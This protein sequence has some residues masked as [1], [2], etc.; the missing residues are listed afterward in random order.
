VEERCRSGARGRLRRRLAATVVAGLAGAMAVA[1]CADDPA[2]PGPP[3]ATGAPDP[4]AGPDL[5]DADLWLTFDDDTPGYDASREFPDALGGPFAG[6]IVAAND[7]R[8]EM[9]AGAGGSGGAVAFPELCKASAGCPR[10]MV[11]V[12]ADPR[13]NPGEADF[14]YGASVWLA[15]DQ[16]TTGSNIVQKGRFGTSGG[17]WKLQ[18]DSADGEPSCVVRSGGEPV[19]VRSSVTI[20]DEAWHRVVCRRA[21]GAV[22]I[23]V[24]GTVDRGAASPGSV[25]NEWPVRI[26]SPG[27]DDGDDQFHG[28]VDDVFLKIEG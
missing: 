18:V 4:G 25:S 13:L 22:S 14:S 1:G 21:E 20:A 27:V 12:M 5:E 16:T 23:S 9:V 6:R 8:V 26:G 15:P 11:E 19:V 17:Q 3:P 7:G 28:R 10:A 2:V 24:D